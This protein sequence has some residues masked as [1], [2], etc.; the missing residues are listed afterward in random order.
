MASLF[1]EGLILGFAIAITLIL[2][3]IAIGFISEYFDKGC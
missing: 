1:F 2:V 3:V